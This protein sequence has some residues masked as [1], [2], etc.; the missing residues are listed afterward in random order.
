MDLLGDYSD[1]DDDDRSNSP[2]TPISQ[3]VTI[4]SNSSSSAAMN[5]MMPPTMPHPQKPSIKA[6]AVKKP[7]ATA[8]T[9]TSTSTAAQKKRG[10][11]IL[12]LH[13]V[14]PPHI[15]E[16]LTKSQAN[17]D[18]SSD[19]DD[20]DD[21]DAQNQNTNNKKKQAK[22][23]V[24]S[25]SNKKPAAS[26]HQDAGI[27][28]FLSA[29]NSAKTTNK[30]AKASSYN[31]N[32]SSSTAA[33]AMKKNEAP[34]SQLGAAFLSVTSTTTTRTK[35]DGSSTATSNDNP[36]LLL[37]LPPASSPTGSDAR[38]TPTGQGEP[39]SPSFYQPLSTSPRT[40]FHPFRTTA[41]N[42][43]AAPPVPTV[44]SA[45]ASASASSATTTSIRRPMNAAPRYD[46][47]H[48]Q[49]AP[50]QAP[51]PMP[52]PAPTTAADI[53]YHQSL[54]LAA[55][56]ADPAATAGNHR[57]NKRKLQKALRAGQLDQA[58]GSSNNV[59]LNVTQMDQAH[60]TEY[61]PQQETYSTPANGVQVVSTQMYNPKAGSDLQAD[62]ADLK[63][64]GKNQIN[65][66]MQSAATF[67]LQQARGG[68]AKV[69]NQRAG[70][71]QKYG[72]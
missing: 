8:T 39:S 25:N 11:K 41:A 63:A 35:K 34:T 14:L 46:N 30:A 37:N 27:A 4:H 64:K 70:A 23:N 29:L 20:D 2:P 21:W 48:R 66:L 58:L 22:T 18:D 71:K 59:D 57:K 52:M 19:D 17:G 50:A 40:A 12:S 67:Q 16:Q 13:S 55:P 42:V 56:A 31:T 33:V 69:N 72:W 28:S 10:K 47:R 51:P 49:P 36:G 32:A 5:M 54:P 6:A 68:G 7:A 24:N 38:Q 60:P 53:S 61:V 44:A 26:H 43:S 15:L 45:V 1:S 65:Q 9:S 3:K 62:A